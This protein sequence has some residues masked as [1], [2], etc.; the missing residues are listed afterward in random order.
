MPNFCGK[1][2]C[3]NIFWNLEESDKGRETLKHLPEAS[4]RIEPLTISRTLSKAQNY[5]FRHHSFS[6]HL[7]YASCVRGIL[8]NPEGLTSVQKPG[9]EMLRGANSDDSGTRPS[10]SDSMCTGMQSGWGEC[11][12]REKSVS[13]RL[14]HLDLPKLHYPTPPPHSTGRPNKVL[15]AVWL[16]SQGEREKNSNLCDHFSYSMWDTILQNV[17][18]S[19]CRILQ[20]SKWDG[21]KLR[22]LVSFIAL[23]A[24]T[25]GVTPCSY[26]DI[27]MRLSPF[28]QL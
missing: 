25:K 10:F 26:C 11:T 20:K 17:S 9:E 7:L 19:P 2:S 23:V 22:V 21:E 18:N 4:K 6:K 28:R 8:L 3:E 24:L 1:S 12:L 16:E 27:S 13:H 5:S 14:D 15:W